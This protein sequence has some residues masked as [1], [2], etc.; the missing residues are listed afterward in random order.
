MAEGS[1]A[2]RFLRRATEPTILDVQKKLYGHVPA[3]DVIAQPEVKTPEQELT[4]HSLALVDALDRKN[5][6]SLETGNSRLGYEI[7]TDNNRTFIFAQPVDVDTPDHNSYSGESFNRRIRN[8][9]A[10]TANGARSIW[11]NKGALNDDGSIGLV[12]GLTLDNRYEWG[13]NTFLYELASHTDAH[14]DDNGRKKDTVYQKTTTAPESRFPYGIGTDTLGY[15]NKKDG[16][17]AISIGRHNTDRHVWITPQMGST[18]LGI[19][20]ASQDLV[21]KAVDKSLE[22]AKKKREI[23]PKKVEI[24]RAKIDT[25]LGKLSS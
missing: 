14:E 2:D 6:D 12:D 18:L 25:V 21:E 13:E 9:V 17:E 20:E 23:P 8:Y 3:A 10:I 15:Q 7:G 19:S 11:F 24:E 22:A 5:I 1:F 4:E 16:L